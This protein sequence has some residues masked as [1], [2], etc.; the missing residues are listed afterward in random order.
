MRRQI[1]RSN[2]VIIS[3]V[4]LFC[5]LSMLACSPDMSDQ[6]KYRPFRESDF[7]SD[8]RS[9]RPALEG[10]VARGSLRI[11]N[12]VYTGRENGEL[13]ER[14]P[15]PLTRALLDRGRERFNIFCTPCHGYLGDGSGMVVQ[16]GFQR[17]SSYH[18]DRLREMP[19]GYFFDVIT[20]GHGAM[21][22]Y[23]SRIPTVDRWA[24]TAYIRALQLSQGAK[25]DE[26]P[27]ED[28]QILTNT[29]K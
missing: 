29:K 4:L 17:P 20:H 27:P 2:R 23:A 26:L 25:M 21:A 9:M 13:L 8:G 10:T 28:R 22:S 24:I 15:V 5:A 6:P 7:F 11:N 1:H 14:I 18:I 12:P 3:G 19:D 16:R